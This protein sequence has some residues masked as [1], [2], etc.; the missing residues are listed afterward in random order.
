MN[1]QNN[2]KT[3]TLKVSYKNIPG[4]GSGD[5]TKAKQ[6]WHD[7]N[8]KHDIICTQENKAKT[9]DDATRWFP[10]KWK[11]NIHCSLNSDSETAMGGILIAINPNSDIKFLEHIEI[12]KGRAQ[13]IKVKWKNV[14]TLTIVNIYLH[15][16]E[17]QNIVLERNN[18]GRILRKTAGHGDKQQKKKRWPGKT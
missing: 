17:T 9:F 6:L 4:K 8:L 2:N 7:R 1:K 14:M 13:L 5:S 3:H 10:L 15:C 12:D 18:D 11:E 16:G